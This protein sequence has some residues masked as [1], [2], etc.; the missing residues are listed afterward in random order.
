MCSVHASLCVS[1]VDTEVF[2]YV[3]MQCA[4]GWFSASGASVCTACSAGKYVTK[5]DGG[6]DADSCT[7]VSIHVLC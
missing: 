2:A 5:A 4:S 7:S 6:T 3:H 1:C